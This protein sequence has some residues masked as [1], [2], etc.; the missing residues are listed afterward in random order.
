M[1]Y[2][3]VSYTE[4]EFDYDVSKGIPVLAFLKKNIELISVEKSETNLV[5]RKKL[6]EFRKKALNGRVA[7]FW[8]ST[9]DLKYVIHSRQKGMIIWQN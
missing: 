7:R 9:E 5:R 2:N 3:N 8:N 1:D 4:K 6:D